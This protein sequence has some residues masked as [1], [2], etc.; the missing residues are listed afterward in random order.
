MVALAIV[1]TLLLVALALSSGAFAFFL[2]GAWFGF[3]VGCV[4]LALFTRG[5]D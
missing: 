3:V 2:G 1:A 5:R 4:A